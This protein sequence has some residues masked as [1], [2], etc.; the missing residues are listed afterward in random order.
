MSSKAY[1]LVF[2]NCEHFATECRNGKKWSHQSGTTAVGI[3]VAAT[4]APL[5]GW[6]AL[7]VGLCAKGFSKMI[8]EG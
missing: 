4:T 5:L 7:L 1:N 8:V 6:T 2:N 3:L